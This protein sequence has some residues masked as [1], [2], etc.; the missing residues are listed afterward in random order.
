MIEENRFWVVAPYNSK[1]PKLNSKL[2]PFVQIPN[3]LTLN[4]V[5]RFFPTL[6]VCKKLQKWSVY[7]L[8]NSGKKKSS[9]QSS[10]PRHRNKRKIPP[11]TGI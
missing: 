4:Q 1:L 7:L 10:I 3:S 5:P 2:T 9:P 6:K 8:P 11:L